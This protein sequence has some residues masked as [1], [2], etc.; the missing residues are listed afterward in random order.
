[1]GKAPIHRLRVSSWRRFAAMAE[2]T[3][4]SRLRGYG[5]TLRR[6][7]VKRGRESSVM[8]RR[9]V[10]SFSCQLNERNA[11][12]A[13][14]EAASVLIMIVLKLDL[15]LPTARRTAEPQRHLRSAVRLWRLQVCARDQAR[16]SHM[17]CR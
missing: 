5:R 11:L 13:A 17:P 4:T 8:M 15:G 1:M 10:N 16:R 14:E 2:N 3:T 6:R 7:R 9:G 12:A